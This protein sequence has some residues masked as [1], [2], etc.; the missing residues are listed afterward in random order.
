MDECTLCLIVMFLARTLQQ[1]LI[2]VNLSGFR[3]LHMDQG[4]SHLLVEYPSRKGSFYSHWSWQASSL[5][6]ARYD[7]IPCFS[8]GFFCPLV[9]VS[10]WQP[11]TCTILTDWPRQ[12]ITSAQIL[13]N[14]SSHS[15]LIGAATV[16]ARCGILNQWAIGPTTFISFVLGHW[17]TR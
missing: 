3:A 6:S 16:T 13:G 5:C 2:K 11:L 15:F 17:L 10:E 12:I 8:G 14:S 9:F 7:D 4:C 1:L